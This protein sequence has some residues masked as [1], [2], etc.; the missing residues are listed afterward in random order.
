MEPNV[1]AQAGFFELYIFPWIIRIAVAI[2]I[3]FVG[4]WLAEKLT[5]LLRRLMVRAQMDM[6]LVQFLGNIAYM[7]L[8]AVVIIAALDQIGIQTTSMLAVFGAAGLAVGLAL[9]D[10]LGNFASGVMLILFRPFKVGDQIEAGSVTGIVEEIRIFSTLLRTA[11]NREI[12][13]P[14]GTIANGVII[15]YNAKPT[16][17]V[18]LVFSIGYDD[19]LRQARS[20]LEKIVREQPLVLAEPASAVTL[21]DLAENSINFTVN[22][23][24]KVEDYGTVRATLLENVKLAF[25]DA[26]ISIPFPQRD[27][28]LYMASGS[29]P[30]TAETADK[31]KKTGK[32]AGRSI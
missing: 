27:V 24:T 26:G 17:R 14:N 29:L 11:D 15:N 18:D 31:T 13:V 2:A 25:D 8:L 1:V 9:K 12:T 23:W 19:D 30:E 3:W 5:E 16:R 21:S 32:T 10:S 20:I 28:H 6:T 7:V 4:K 22:A